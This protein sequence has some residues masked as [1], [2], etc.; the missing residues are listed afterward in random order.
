MSHE[1]V[2]LG[3]YYLTSIGSPAGLLLLHANPLANTVL[4]S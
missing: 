4:A 2:R 3:N 1:E